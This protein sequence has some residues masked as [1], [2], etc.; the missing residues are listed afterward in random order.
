MAN[1][2]EKIYTLTAKGNLHSVDVS[3]PLA[4]ESCFMTSLSSSVGEIIF[5]ASFSEVF[6]VKSKDEIIIWNISD[7]KELLRICL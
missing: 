4:S 5:P 1:S 2:K 7:Q 6:A 3:L